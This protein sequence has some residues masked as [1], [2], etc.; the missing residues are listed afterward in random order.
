LAPELGM[1]QAQLGRAGW[2]IAHIDVDLTGYAPKAEIQVE[3]FDGKWLLARVDRLGRCSVERFVRSRHLGMSDNTRGRR[4]LSPQV[5][6]QFL[7]RDRLSSPGDLLDYI[8][9][10]ISNNAASP[11]PLDH[12]H[13]AWRA[14]LAPQV[15]GAGQGR[16]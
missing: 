1:L 4:P 11:V 15:N 6:D 16:A 14:V 12:M 2:A 13:A 9:C 7:G 3:S 10:Y 8:A 5:E